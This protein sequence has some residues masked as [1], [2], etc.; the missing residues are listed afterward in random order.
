MSD[1][2]GYHKI[3]AQADDECARFTKVVCGRK[4]W[5]ILVAELAHSGELFVHMGKCDTEHLI[6]RSLTLCQTVA[7]L[8]D[9]GCAWGYWTTSCDDTPV[10]VWGWYRAGED[11]ELLSETHDPHD[12]KSALKAL[13]A[14]YKGNEA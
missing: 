14:C 10:E 9:S 3:N 12:L 6:N 7:L 4:G 8:K 11:A 5:K 2:Y 13:V 1:N